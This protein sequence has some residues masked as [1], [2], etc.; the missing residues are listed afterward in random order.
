MKNV[1]LLGYPQIV[2]LD[3]K[4]QKKFFERESPNRGVEPRFAELCRQV[5]CA[6]QR[7]AE[8]KKCAGHREA[9]EITRHLLLQ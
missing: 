6:D 7:E 1:S 2:D 5:N 8:R 9:E 4:A 3:F